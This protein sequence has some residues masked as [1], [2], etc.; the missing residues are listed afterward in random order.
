MTTSAIYVLEKTTNQADFDYCALMM[1]KS[2]P[3]ITLEMD[4]DLC[5]Q[6]FEGVAK[7][8]FVIKINTE[9]AGFVILQIEGTFKGYIQ[10]ICINED[11]R[12]KGL[13]KILLN[14]CEERIMKISPNIFI[15]VSSFNTRALELYTDF[16]F[17]IIGE[18]PNFIKEGFTEILLWKSFGPKIGFQNLKE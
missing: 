12:R 16:G 3:W 17:K 10:T 13:G 4:F 9:I 11:F 8:V 6:A 18:L 7:E 14:F 2:D 1:A 15:C 5:S